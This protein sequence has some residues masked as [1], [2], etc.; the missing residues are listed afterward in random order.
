M[1][2]YGRSAR[3][4]NDYNAEVEFCKKHGFDFMQIWYK[5]GGFEFDKLPNPKES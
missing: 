5:D 3:W 1:I 2:R 4:H